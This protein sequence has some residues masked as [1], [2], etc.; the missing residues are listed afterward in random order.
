MKIERELS[1]D[2][3]PSILEDLLLLL[4]LQYINDSLFGTDYIIKQTANHHLPPLPLLTNTFTCLFQTTGYYDMSYQTPTTL[5]AVRDGTLTNVP[6]SISDGRFT[7]G[8][9]T[10]PVPSTLSQQTST[11][12][13]GHQAQPMLAA[14]T[15]AAPFFYAT[16]YNPM[17]PTYQFGA[18][19]PVSMNNCH[20]S[21][22]TIT[23]DLNA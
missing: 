1:S 6:Y 11:L 15:G 13:Q 22:G 7:R 23:G 2:F 17:Q 20:V 12:T 10:S 4:Q 19:Y 16:A 14:Q 21:V 18:V 9:N 5:P 8:D 3:L